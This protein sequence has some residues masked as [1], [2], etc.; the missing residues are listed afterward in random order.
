MKEEIKSQALKQKVPVLLS[1]TRIMGAVIH[2][3]SKDLGQWQV[4]FWDD[5]GFSGHSIRPTKEKAIE[6]AMDDGYLRLDLTGEFKA[7]SLS[8][9]FVDGIKSFIEARNRL[10]SAQ[11]ITT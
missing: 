7:I 10:K 2:P 9:K 6:L 1:R 8:D 4:S 5:R 11:T 3:S